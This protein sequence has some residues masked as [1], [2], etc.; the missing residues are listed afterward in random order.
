[1]ER[2]HWHTLL[3][4]ARGYSTPETARI[5]GYSLDWTRK[6]VRRYNADGPSAVGDR[7]RDNAGAT[8]LLSDADRAALEEVLRAVAPDDGPWTGPKV[9]RWIAARTGREGLHAQ[10][11]WEALRALGYTAQTPRPRHAK[12]ERAAQEAFKKN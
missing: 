2:T 9:A 5:V 1:V 6:I 12:A 7:R 4:K 10:R 8:P 3:L 11:G